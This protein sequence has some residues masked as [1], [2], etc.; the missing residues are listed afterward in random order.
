MKLYLDGHPFRYAMEQMML[1]VFPSE[2]PEFVDELPLDGDFAI[3]TLKETP[4]SLFGIA[5]V[6]RN[7]K[8]E[9]VTTRMK[10]SEEELLYKRNA[11][12]AL[13]LA[14]YRAS[15]PFLKTPPP[16]GAMTGIRPAKLAARLYAEGHDDRA[17]DRILKDSYH[18]VARRRALACEVAKAGMRI[19]AGNRT[20]DASVYVGIPFCV[21][22]CKYCSFVSHS[23]GQAE[24]LVEPYLTAL[25]LE[26]EATGKAA[27]ELGITVKTVYV[28][29][30]TPTALSAEQLDRVL[31]GIR[32]HF[33]LS[34]CVEFT[35]E[36][37]RPDTM[38]AEKLSVIAKN[39]ATRI[40]VNPQTMNDDVLRLIGRNHTAQDVVDMVHT[41]RETTN[42][43]INMDLIA[44]LPGD[45]FPSFQNTV[46][47]TLALDP[48]NIT[49][50]TL[51]LKKA[52]SL[53]AERLPSPSGE[54]VQKMVD[55]AA[56]AVQS[57]D[58]RPYYLYRQ[59]YM[60][61]NLENVGYAKPGQEGL[62]N[63]FIMEEIHTILSLGAG[64][65]SKLVSPETGKLTRIFNLKYPYEYNGDH[66]RLIRNADEI[67]AFYRENF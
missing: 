16:W 24:H 3:L 48:E 22:R 27:K 65:V 44:G 20:M 42:L 15:R 25:F 7:G 34:D 11:Q 49:V 19:K 29:G 37:G 62:Y 32:K 18:V 13:K 55:F 23:I 33:D 67:R 30:G 59:K 40:S 38:D 54:E 61:G 39:G 43:A 31:G 51:A 56:K 58:F 36:A 14:F 17:V 26:M 8:R 1:T 64:G 12:Q 4:K 2:R 6:C 41:V 57:R 46:R 9:T 21:S 35:V 28:G 50:H 53:W 66:D 63:V 52:A 5:T 47:Q 60:S 45:S 10:N